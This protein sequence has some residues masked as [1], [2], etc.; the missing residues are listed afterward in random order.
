[1][2]VSLMPQ[3]KRH[4]RYQVQH[5]KPLYIS[6]ESCMGVG[7]FEVERDRRVCG[8][9]L[10]VFSSSEMEKGVQVLED[11]VRLRG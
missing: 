8:Y 6:Q 5:H 2:Q 10:L 11:M 7:N 1:M 4:A 3:R 9:L